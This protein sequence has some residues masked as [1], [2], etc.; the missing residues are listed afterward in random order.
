LRKTFAI[1]RLN[2]RYV[3]Q[4]ITCDTLGS[5]IWNQ[6]KAE[7]Q[8]KVVYVNDPAQCAQMLSNGRI[9][10]M[11]MHPE[12]AADFVRRGHTVVDDELGLSFNGHLIISKQ[13]PNG[14]DMIR[15]FNQSMRKLMEQ[16][17]WQPVFP[18]PAR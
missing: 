16:K 1:P 5:T 3:A 2:P 12:Q 14:E 4:R 18:V 7:A 15:R 11:M 9:D 8:I 6:L 13:E 10:F 17:S